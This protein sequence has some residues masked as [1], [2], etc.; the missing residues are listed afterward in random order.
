MF[1]VLA[2]FTGFT[3]LHVMRKRFL[4]VSVVSTWSALS[5]Y[6]LYASL[7]VSVVTDNERKEDY[8]P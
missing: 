5:T 8:N 2:F 7:L 1:T 3:P 6:P 4:L